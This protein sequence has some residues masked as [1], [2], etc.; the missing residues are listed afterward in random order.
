MGKG[1]GPEGRERLRRPHGPRAIAAAVL[2]RVERDKAFA[3]AALESEL[4]RSPQVAPRDRALATELVYGSLRVMPWLIAELDRRATRGIGTLDDATRVHVCI[5]AYQLYFLARVPAF[6]AVSEA[7]EAVRRSRGA[8]VAAFANAVLR[9]LAKERDAREGD[10]ATLRDALHEEAIC[11]S[12][13]PWIRANLARSLGEEGARGFLVG[14]AEPPPL[15]IRVGDLGERDAWVA[16][17]RASLPEATFEPGRV[18]PLAILARGAGRPQAL[19][20][21]EDGAWTVQEEGAQL[22]ALA[23][24]ARPGE[25]VLDACAG[26][27]NK[28]ALLARAVLPSGAGEAYRAAAVPSFAS[29]AVGAVDAADIHPNKL[30]RLRLELA[31][32]HLAPRATFAVDWAVGAGECTGRYDRVLVDAPCSG[33]GTLRR[34]PE[35]AQRLTQENLADIVRLQRAILAR[36]CERVQPG[37]SIVYA[38]CSVLCEEGEGVVD[39]VLQALPAMERAPFPGEPANKLAG[40]AP[41]LRLLPELHRTDGYFLASLRKK[42]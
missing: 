5:G 14:A 28:T 19:P 33:L 27:G 15:G 21:W 29:A 9:K 25:T 26:R 11:K 22:V 7:V 16:R 34:K 3:S 17:L 42:R 10:A 39:A 35:L 40:E 4:A 23:L 20:G 8:K 36:T 30:D 38:V 32:L 2:L 13:V 18:S 41:V 12:V 24:G 31:R 37:G 1:A 6:A